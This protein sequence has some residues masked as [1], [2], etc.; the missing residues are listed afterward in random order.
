MAIINIEDFLKRSLNTDGNPKITIGRLKPKYKYL[1]KPALKKGRSLIGKKYDEL[2]IINN[3]K[4]Y[5]SELIYEIFLNSD[6]NLF[7]LEPMTFKDPE[8]NNFM[9]GE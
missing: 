2:F 3:D 1:I 8:N 4:Y 7:K 6:H 5:C 9:K